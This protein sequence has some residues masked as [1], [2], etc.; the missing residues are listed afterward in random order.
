METIKIVIDNE[1]L[2]KYRKHYFDKYPKRKK[3]PIEKC[4]EPSLNSWMIL[5]RFSMNLMKQNWK[6]FGEWVIDE[7]GLRDKKIE[8]CIVIAEY[9]F[10]SKRRHD[11]SNYS[12]KF[13]LDAFVSSGFL[14]DDD[15]DHI[16]SLTLKGNY[17]KENSRTEISVIY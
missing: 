10:D 7:Y 17:S 2:N 3:F 13:L 5:P 15:F 6:E 14:I 11:G 1:K 12:L 9:F 4:I 8:K 16:E